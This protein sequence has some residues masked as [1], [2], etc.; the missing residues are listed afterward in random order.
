MRRLKRLM[1]VGAALWLVSGCLPVPATALP[2]ATVTPTVAP[3]PTATPVWFP[4]TATPT[5]LPPT[6]I[7]TPTPDMAAGAGAP[8]AAASFSTPAGWYSPTGFAG[9]FGVANGVLSLSALHPRADM[10]VLQRD[11]PAFNFYLSVIAEP[12]VCRGEDAYGIVVRASANGGR[13]YRLG[14]YCNGKAF[15]EA[16][17]GGVPVPRVT[18]EPA[19]V[20]PGAPSRATMSVRAAGKTINFAVNGQVL[21]TISDDLSPYGRD[22]MGFFARPAGDEGMIVTFRNLTVRPVLPPP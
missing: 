11:V 21:F 12:Q 8:L 15:A 22:F 9:R 16:V 1:V 7:P 2:A 17:E 14:L 5:P 6:P 4:P 10:I 19:S 18:P 20:P 3:T 13:Y